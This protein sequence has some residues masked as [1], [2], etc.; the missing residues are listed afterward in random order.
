MKY[1]TTK[2][3]LDF[4]DTDLQRTVI[5]MTLD[6]MSQTDIAK[7]LGKNSKRIH[8]LVSNIHRKAALQG[9]APAYNVNRQTAPSFTTKRISTAY[10]TDG[11][12]VLQWHIQE[13]ERQKIEELIAQFVEGFK[14]ELTG[15]HTPTVPL[16][17]IDDDYMVSYIIGDHHLGMLAHHTET[18]G[19]D[20]DVKISQR[21]LE[22]AVD[23]LVSVAPAGKVGVLVNL[24]D[25]MHVNDS[26]SSTPN[27]KNLLDSDGR[28]S[29]TIRAA[30]NVIKRTV[31]RMLEKHA[32]VWLVNVRGNHDP[33]AA[34]W[35]NE[36]MRLY[37]ED[38]PRVRVF[39]NASKFIW[40]QWGKNLVVTH[41]G[42]RIKM[43]N[44]HGSIVS[45]L[46]KEWGEAD[47]TFVWTGHIHH[48]NQE[49][50]GGALFESWNILAPADA[51]HSGSGYASSRSM[52]C[53][54]LHK[55]FGEEGRLKVNV[56]R[57]Q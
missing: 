56:E 1:R 46:R 21:L 8:S 51:W 49:E 37:F 14:D 48:K 2:E 42:D 55:D 30:S 45:N 18:M 33:D 5:Q 19:E 11:D 34:L 28:Y 44:L 20:Y 35:L 7:D 3:H 27:S 31:L 6:G 24:G 57:I 47:H 25:F 52:T 12:I 22:N 38:D 40:W 32:E 36:V 26:T 43:S 41:H 17:G 50:Y 9:V 39:D 23:R 4:C 53:V 54:I 29:K 13:P 10:N 16:T 15:I